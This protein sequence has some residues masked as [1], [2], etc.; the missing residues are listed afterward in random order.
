MPI[1][2]PLGGV[3]TPHGRGC[4]APA[5]SAVKRSLFLESECLLK[6]PSS[7]ISANCFKGH[8]GSAFCPLIPTATAFGQKNP[9]VTCSG[10]RGNEG[11]PHPSCASLSRQGS[12]GGEPPPQTLCF[13][14]LSPPLPPPP[15]DPQILRHLSPAFRSQ[16]ALSQGLAALEGTRWRGCCVAQQPLLSFQPGSKLHLWLPGA[17]T[18]PQPAGTHKSF[19]EVFSATSFTGENDRKDVSIPSL[20]GR[21]VRPLFAAGSR[22][23]I[24]QCG[25][26]S[27][28]AQKS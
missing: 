18:S 21:S 25:P 16:V 27:L 10:W 23:S 11:L 26:S 19:L 22:P 4:T 17:R 14:W 20:S 1:R 12:H 8:S 6:Q 7:L 5:S 2:G 28:K 13:P 9:V 15:R 24:I 3:D